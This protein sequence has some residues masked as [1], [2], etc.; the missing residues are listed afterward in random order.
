M[1]GATVAAGARLNVA[2]EL[3]ALPLRLVT[4]TEYEP[5]D[6]AVGFEI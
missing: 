4:T 3:V 6:D 5:S 2:E 1:T